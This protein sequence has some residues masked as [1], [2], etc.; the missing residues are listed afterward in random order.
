MSLGA[1][2]GLSPSAT[3]SAVGQLAFVL[4]ALVLWA[5]WMYCQHPARDRNSPTRRLVGARA[6][7]VVMA[8]FMVLCAVRSRAPDPA[9]IV[10][11]LSRDA[12]FTSRLVGQPAISSASRRLTAINLLRNHVPT[13]NHRLDYLL[14][15][16]GTAL[17]TLWLARDREDMAVVWR[18][19]GAIVVLEATM[20]LMLI[21]HY[22]GGPLAGAGAM[23][24]LRIGA[25]AGLLAGGWLGGLMAPVVG[26]I[27]RGWREALPLGGLPRSV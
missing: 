25:A 14:V 8:G 4:G 16:S 24:A 2:V 7:A 15:T 13:P 10:E 21:H 22:R 6:V 19:L 23:I 11:A 20:R 9:P 27:H 3:A 17:L 5:T 1:T 12:A 26:V 18:V